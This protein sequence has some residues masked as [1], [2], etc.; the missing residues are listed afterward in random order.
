MIKTGQKLLHTVILFSIFLLAGGNASAQQTWE[1]PIT[2]YGNGQAKLVVIKAGKKMKSAQ[3]VGTK[4]YYETGQMQREVMPDNNGKYVE[5]YYY[6]NGQLAKIRPSDSP[7]G[8]S[9]EGECKSYYSNG[10]LWQV[11]K[12]SASYST[13]ED[14]KEYYS[15]GILKATGKTVGFGKAV[16]VWTFYNENGEVEKTE[17]F[18]EGRKLTR[19]GI[20]EENKKYDLLD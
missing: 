2:K 14:Y 6:P 5:K 16:G 3:Q 17:D 20:D 8:G 19:T 15:T 18:G 7:R 4:A 12:F 9:S 13:K 11:G 1:I 10:Q